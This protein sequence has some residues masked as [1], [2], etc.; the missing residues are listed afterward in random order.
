MTPERGLALAGPLAD[1]PAPQ[2][3]MALA[4]G[5]PRRAVGLARARYGDAPADPVGRLVLGWALLRWERVAEAVPLLEAAQ[6]AFAASGIAEL[7]GWCHFARLGARQLAGAGPELQAEWSSLA[8]A[9]EASGAFAWAA[10]ARCEQVAQLNLLGRHGEARALAAA[11]A[12]AVERFGGPAERARHRHVQGVAHAGCGDL[13]AAEDLLAAAAAGFADLAYSVAVARV[14]FEQSWVASRREQFERARAQLEEARASF[15]DAELPFRVALC[16]RD[17]GLIASRQGDFGAA[18]ASTMGARERLEA[19]G[20]PVLVAA[21]DLNLGVVAHY[22]GLLDLA[23]AAYERAYPA[24]VAAGLERMALVTRRNQ[25]AVWLEGGR[26]AAAL[27][28][29]D[30]IGPAFTALGDALEATEVLVLKARAYGDGDPAAAL[31]CFAAAEERFAALGNQAAAAEC[32]LEAG[33]L[34]LEQGD[35]A[36][37]ASAF[38]AAQPLLAGRPAHLWRAVYGLGRIAELRGDDAEALAHYGAAGELVATMRRGLASEHA[39]SGLF[40]QARH[41]YAAALALAARHSDPALLLAFAEQQR[42][43]ALRHQ[44][45]GATR[46]AQSDELALRQSRLRAALDT[47]GSRAELDLALRDYVGLLLVSRHQAPAPAPPIPPFDLAGARATLTAAYGEGWTL[48]APLVTPDELLLITMT[49]DE[50]T[51]AHE[52][53]DPQLAELLER[54]CL[55]AY[56]RHT[57]RDLAA[58]RSGAEPSWPTLSELGRRLIPQAVLDRLGQDHRLLIVPDGPLHAVPWAALRVAGRWLV[59]RAIVEL[60]PALGSLRTL[61]H[62]PSSAAPALVV[63]CNSFGGRAPELPYALATLDLVAEHWPGPVTAMA[64]QAATRTGLLERGARGELAAYGLLHLAAHA[65]IGGPG[66]LAHIKLADEDLLVDEALGLGLRDSLVV[67]A[68]CSGAASE[69]LPG[70]ELLGLGRALLAAGARAVVAG[71]WQL[72]DE[73]IVRLLAPYYKALATG[74]DPA[75][76]LAHAQRAMLTVA[77]ADADYQAL[78]RSPYVWASLCVTSVGLARQP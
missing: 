27:R 70:D 44:L 63:G 5:D 21:C 50:L 61:A 78:L 23:E 4:D 3:L 60:L 8:A 26:P 29:L 37:A 62:R 77:D 74:A 49:P 73:G 59:E 42:A 7:A 66:L 41:L 12:T 53:C 67:L 38:A 13:A 2:Q 54:A 43:L 52:P 56:R 20:Y 76:A 45:A 18:I 32:R 69:V 48:L 51:L 47:G 64:G 55:P 57:M 68:A 71:L 10:R 40:S 1:E 58:L 17:L 65:H 28:L 72:Y 33:W 16:E 24:Y 39:S 75:A 15:R 30:S 22:S 11:I 25:A 46:P 14:R 6:A 35:L 34:H 19:L 31:A 9:F 36:Q